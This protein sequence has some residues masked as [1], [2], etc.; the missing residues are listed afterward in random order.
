MTKGKKFMER[1]GLLLTAAVGA[2]I[3]SAA[4][5]DKPD[6]TV[7]KLG[8]TGLPDWAAYKIQAEG[9]WEGDV[10]SLLGDG[11]DLYWGWDRGA[12]AYVEA[13]GDFSL[14]VRIKEG[15]AAH[16]ARWN[17]PQTLAYGMRYNKVGIYQKYGV[18]VRENL[19]T[20][21][22][23][24]AL[25][26]DHYWKT[27][28]WFYRMLPGIMTTERSGMI[29]DGPAEGFDQVSD[30]HF[31]ITREGYQIRYFA[32]QGGSGPFSEILPNNS[33]KNE[34][35]PGTGGPA[36]SPRFS[37]TVYV[38]VA[39]SSGHGFIH[40][41]EGYVH[42]PTIIEYDNI[43]LEKAASTA[44][45]FRAPA[46]GS[47]IDFRTTEGGVR[48]ALPE[49]R[50][51]ERATVYDLSGRRVLMM[52]GGATSDVMIPTSNQLAAGVYRLHLREAGGD[53]HTLPFTVSR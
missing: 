53:T 45:D 50:T 28:S 52:P 9:S 32:R 34:S 47:L 33:R 8:A 19:E 44:A 17:D 12:F 20:T 3:C 23:M 51:I 5:Q 24:A 40:R 10:F 30:I 27:A 1:S 13:E 15:R 43:V 41:E 2:L 29:Y 46:S 39:L 6:F 22:R 31:R 11:K 36:P 26:C 18:M 48:V 49:G 16:K 14:T 21:S 37:G 42:C 7:V 38:G 25:M 4:A 35:Y